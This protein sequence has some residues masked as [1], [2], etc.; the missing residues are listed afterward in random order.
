MD[1][2]EEVAGG[3]VVACGDGAI[4][5]ELGEEV[6]DQMAR[7]VEVSIERSRRAAAASWWDDR[8]FAGSCEGLDHP[9]VGIERLVGDQRVGLHVRKEVIGADQ[10][11][12]LAAAQMEA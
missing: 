11:M 8:G 3:L 7:L 6:L 2:G 5:L 4:L 9:I 12:R 1:G 10:V